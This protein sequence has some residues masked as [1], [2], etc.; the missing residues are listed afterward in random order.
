MMA[1]SCFVTFL[2]SG[3]TNELK[4]YFCLKEQ[5]RQRYLLKP[6]QNFDVGKAK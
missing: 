1:H 5:K 3:I 4:K 2:K 6:E